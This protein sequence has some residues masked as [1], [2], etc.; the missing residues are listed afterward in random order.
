MTT[1]DPQNLEQ[2]K[3]KR[4]RRRETYQTR[5]ENKR[6][7]PERDKMIETIKSSRERQSEKFRGRKI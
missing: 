5:E 4:G 7:N 1:R 3:V 6:H 2:E